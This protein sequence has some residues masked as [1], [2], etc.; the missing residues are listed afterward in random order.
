MNEEERGYKFISYTFQS[1]L[2]GQNI[3]PYLYHKGENVCMSDQAITA[4]RFGGRSRIKGGYGS[5]WL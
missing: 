3:L 2:C 1:S 5:V 4:V